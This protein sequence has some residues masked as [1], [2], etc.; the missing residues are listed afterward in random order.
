[1]GGIS[2]Y[3]DIN[4]GSQQD[5]DNFFARLSRNQELSSKGLA[6]LSG[7]VG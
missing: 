3:G 7:S 2:I 1:M 6:S 5:A 4:I